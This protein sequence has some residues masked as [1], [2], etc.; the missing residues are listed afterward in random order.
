MYLRPIATRETGPADHIYD[1]IAEPR[2]MELISD[3]TEETWREK[4]ERT[5]PKTGWKAR[6][7]PISVLSQAEK[8]EKGNIK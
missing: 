6:Y 8:C 3:I 7:I 2:Q 4:P 1:E 5:K